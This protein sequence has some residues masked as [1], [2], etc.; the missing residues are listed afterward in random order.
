MCVYPAA[1]SRWDCLVNKRLD[2]SSPGDQ[3]KKLL[4]R[5]NYLTFWISDLN[6]RSNVGDKCRKRVCFHMGK[7]FLLFTSKMMITIF[8]SFLLCF[9]VFMILSYFFAYY[10][11]H[12]SF[13]SHNILHLCSQFIEYIVVDSYQ[14]IKSKQLRERTRSKEDEKFEEKVFVWNLK[15][16]QQ[17]SLTLTTRTNQML[18]LFVVLLNLN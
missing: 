4:P 3:P 1:N 16:K 13:G 11:Q 2:Q 5:T 10:F 6:G 9:Y 8:L 14:K 17:L 7:T 18:N 12:V 15:L